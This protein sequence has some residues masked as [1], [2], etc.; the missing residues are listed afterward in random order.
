MK[1]VDRI[2]DV[3]EW[4]LRTYEDK[5]ANGNAK[6]VCYAGHSPNPSK[7]E[8]SNGGKEDPEYIREATEAWEDVMQELQYKLRAHPKPFLFTVGNPLGGSPRRLRVHLVSQEAEEEVAQVSGMPFSF[9]NAAGLAKLQFDLYKTQ[10]ELEMERNSRNDSRVG[11]LLDNLVDVISDP[12][13]INGLIAA[14]TRMASPAPAAVA[15]Q[16]FASPQAAAKTQAEVGFRQR[17]ADYGDVIKQ[18]LFNSE[19]MVFNV[20]DNLLAIIQDPDKVNRL[21][22]YVNELNQAENE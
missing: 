1:N 16:G 13:I 4:F 6:V 8:F 17:F 18:H 2:E 12:A 15:S 19:D 3:R 7:E 20:M 11:R 22:A 9:N 10:Y 14:V 21:I 5:Q